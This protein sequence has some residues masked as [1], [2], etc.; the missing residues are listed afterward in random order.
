M[1]RRAKGEV[2]SPVKRKSR[3]VNGMSIDIHITWTRREDWY[4]EAPC[5]WALRANGFFDPDDLR[6]VCHGHKRE[7]AHPLCKKARVC[8]DDLRVERKAKESVA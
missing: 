6:A 3:Y 2:S 4:L 8:T 1:P 5:G 7:C